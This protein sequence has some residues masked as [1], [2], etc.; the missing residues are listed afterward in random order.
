MKAELIA[1]H[2]CNLQPMHIRSRLLDD[3]GFREHFGLVSGQVIIIGGALHIDQRELVFATRQMLRD[4]LPKS[5]QDINGDEIVVRID[6]DRILLN[7]VASEKQF[8]FSNL[9]MLSPNRDERTH[10]IKLMIDRFGPTAPDFGFLLREAERR[11]LK[12]DEVGALLLE[13]L[14]GVSAIQARAS[15]AFNNKEAT[16]E[17]LIPD[18]LKYFERFCGPNPGPMQPEQYIGITL[19]EFRRNLIRRDLVRGLDI[20]LLGALRDDLMPSPWV[21]NLSDD[22]IWEGLQSCDYWSEP[23]ALLG[24]IDIALERHGDERFAELARTAIE[25]LTQDRFL[26]P[27]GVDTFELLP[28]LAELVLNRINI[29][30]GGV[31][32]PPF[33]KRMCAW[34]HAGFL[35]RMMRRFSI[36]LQ[37]F[38]DWAKRSLKTAGLFAKM[39]DLRREP[40]FCATEMSPVALRGEIIGR[41]EII[42]ER[43]E[44]QGRRIPGRALLDEAVAKL[45]TTGLQQRWALPGP[46]EGH[47]RP[48]EAGN[49]ELPEDAGRKI[50]EDLCGDPPL[51]ALSKLAYISQFFDLGDE[52]RTR[53]REYVNRIPSRNDTSGFSERIGRLTDAGLVACA[54]R[55][56]ELARV[57]GLSVLR[58]LHWAPSDCN[59]AMILQAVIVAAAAFEDESEWAKWLEDELAQIA[60]RLPAGEVSRVFLDQL[61]ELKKVVRLSLGIHVRAEGIASAA[62]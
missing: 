11:E 59:V 22:E 21:S 26:R 46:L 43:H 20:C 25:K 56:V 10:A 27:D 57:I 18:S 32:L 60:I 17:N 42:C 47:R 14:T 44:N 58:S 62:S 53:V 38:H 3:R 6:K 33:W 5:L 24:A 40:M 36:E 12:D 41:L 48:A 23:F 13:R 29:L 7:A 8:R 35:A 34:M 52:L 28:I 54:Q 19:V 1:E 49:R 30:E 15:A 39:I 55:D 61:R 16:V 51:A 4:R 50:G 9:M 2:L 31:L 37:S 45:S